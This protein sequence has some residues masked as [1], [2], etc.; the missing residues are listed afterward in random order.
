[1]TVETKW[2]SDLTNQNIETKW[3]SDLTKP[4]YINNIHMVA[5]VDFGYTA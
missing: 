1:M 2:Q 3:H 4:K 5:L